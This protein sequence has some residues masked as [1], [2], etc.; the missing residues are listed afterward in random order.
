MPITLAPQYTQRSY[1][2]QSLKALITTKSLRLQYEEEP[3]LYTIWGYDNPEVHICTIWKSVV[4]DGILL[5]GYTQQQND[6]D[7]SDFENNFKA[8]AN[9]PTGFG[10][11]TDTPLQISLPSVQLFSN[12]FKSLEY[13]VTTRDET[14]VSAVSYTVPTGKSF[15]LS[16]FGLYCYAPLPVYGRLK[17][18]GASKV[19]LS[20]SPSNGAN[21]AYTRPT[22]IATA[23]QQVT[24]TIEAELSRGTAW[25]GYTGIEV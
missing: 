12:I 10:A 13:T 11:S 3:D 16:S 7:K 1:S 4:P 2:W 20:A 14:G 6:T 9:A 8:S 15:Y 22:L 23:G 25:L 5:C 18:A 17:V 24:V 19:F 21:E